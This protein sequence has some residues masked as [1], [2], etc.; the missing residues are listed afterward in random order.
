MDVVVVT[1]F[2]K[3]RDSPGEML[4]QSA[5]MYGLAAITSVT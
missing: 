4:L 3:H 2:G 5:L 1:A